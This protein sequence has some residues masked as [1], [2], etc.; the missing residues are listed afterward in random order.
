MGRFSFLQLSF[1]RLSRPFH[2]INPQAPTHVLVIPKKPIAM[3]QDATEEDEPLLGHL[4]VVAAKVAKELGLA[5]GYRLVVNNGKDGAQSVY[6]IHI[7]ILSGRQMSW[8]PG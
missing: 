5:N 3:I 6:H 8:P 2:D 1:P 7:H 4:M